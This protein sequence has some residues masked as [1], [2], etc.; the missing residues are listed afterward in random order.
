[1]GPEGF[2]GFEVEAAEVALDFL[3]MNGTVESVEGAF[4]EDGRVD[5]VLEFFVGPDGGG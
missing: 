5:V 2:A 4:E 1:M 3:F